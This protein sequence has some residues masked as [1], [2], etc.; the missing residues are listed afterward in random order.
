ME[1]QSE[2]HRLPE[3]TVW[4]PWRQLQALPA[5]RMAMCVILNGKKREPRTT[6]R[7]YMCMFAL[8]AW[9]AYELPSATIAV[10]LQVLRLGVLHAIGQVRAA[11]CEVRADVK[12]VFSMRCRS[13]YVGD[14]IHIVR[15]RSGN[16]RSLQ[17]LRLTYRIARRREWKAFHDYRL[18][19]HRQQEG[20]EDH[21][22]V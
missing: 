16:C 1:G 5:G 9:G 10:Y 4:P 8:A 12:L 11:L 19:V 13:Q 3:W 15:P 18:T 6:V 14:G 2:E 21:H 7:C 20:F 22:T 17:E